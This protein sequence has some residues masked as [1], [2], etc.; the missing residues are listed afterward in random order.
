[1]ARNDNTPLVSSSG[2]PQTT[3]LAQ[4]PQ[5]SS[6]SHNVVLAQAL[7][8]V[9]A[10]PQ[11]QSGLRLRLPVLDSLSTAPGVVITRSPPNGDCLFT[12]LAF[13]KVCV[14]DQKVWPADIPGQEK[15]GAILR[16]WYL[17]L[18]RV[19]VER[20]EEINGVML[21]DILMG[22]DCGY[23]SVDEYFDLMRDA[24][25]NPKTWGSWLETTLVAR[26]WK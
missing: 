4:L 6:T 15:M 19:L 16:R 2:A 7:K 14:L 1:M 11:G 20:H 12:A 10:H 22:D 23:A 25:Q 26:R 18:A 5:S 8:G 3:E 17:R 13:I 24:T 21:R 9:Q